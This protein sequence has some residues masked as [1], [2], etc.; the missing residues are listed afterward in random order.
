MAVARWTGHEAALL[1]EAMR[2]PIR[3][4]AERLGVNPRTVTKWRARG[5]S[6]ELLP[7]TALLL[8]SMLRMCDPDVAAVFHAALATGSAD[9]PAD[10]GQ[11]VPVG[12]FTV[13]SHK[14]LPVY[15]GEPL[16]AL[17][18]R[19]R[20]SPAGPGGLEHRVTEVG[21]PDG[22]GARLYLYACGVAVFHLA[23]RRTAAS[24]GELAEWRYRTYATDLV[25]ADERLAELLGPGTPRAGYVLSAYVLED[26]PWEARL[27]PTAMQVLTTPSAV[28]DRGHPDGPRR[29]GDETDRALLTQGYSHPDVVDF[30]SRA[31]SLGLAGWS[32]VAYHPLAPERALAADAIV[33]LELDV[34]ALW[35]LS[36]HILDE[37]EAG[38]DPVMP[39]DYGWRFLRGARSRLTAARPQ[40]TAQHQ[41]MREAILTTSGLPD[42]LRSAQEALRESHAP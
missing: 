40:E 18:T 33:A 27:L 35:A 25:W 19:A 32:G 29:L 28:V 30:G 8:D 7:E 38:R 37:V 3:A 4:Y 23:Q 5:R 41:L 21:H 34:Q 26:S 16:R 11:P 6:I 36:T 1:G 9:S 2:M 42:R 12:P 22:P 31:V 20:P 14:V 17:C 39:A 15:V 10:G 13:V 24:P